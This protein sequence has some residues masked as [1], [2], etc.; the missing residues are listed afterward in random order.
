MAYNKPWHSY[1]DMVVKLQERGLSI[2]DEDKAITYLSRIGYYRLS[3]Y[4]YTFRQLSGPCCPLEKPKGNKKGGTRRITLEEF[5][6]GAKFEDAIYLYVFDK[7]L[8]LLVLDALERIEIAFRVEV[9]HLLG[10]RNAFAYLDKEQ[11]FPKFSQQINPKTGLTDHHDWVSKQ[12]GLINRSREKFIEHNKKK[13]GLPLPIWIACEV[14]DFGALSLL[15]SGMKEQDQD[16]IASKFGMSNGRVLAKWLRSLNYLRNV[17]AHHSRLWNRNIIDQPNLPA[18]T[19]VPWVSHFEGKGSDRLRARP[20]MLFCIVKHL[21]DNIN[22]NSTW[23][24]RLTDLMIN[25]FPDMT[26]IGLDLNSMGVVERWQSLFSTTETADD[27]Q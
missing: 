23:W 27:K 19:E 24:M 17:C 14:W 1:E 16:I 3:G 9:A 6:P 8:R 11:F 10:K 26:H 22:P 13:H 2:T 7:K 18:S 15:Y 21:M 12:A 20:F 4:W 5:K 25:E